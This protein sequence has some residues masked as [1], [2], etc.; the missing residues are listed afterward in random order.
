MRTQDTKYASFSVTHAYKVS[1]RYTS[2]QSDMKVALPCC[3]LCVGEHK[4]V[5]G[6]PGAQRVTAAKEQLLLMAYSEELRAE[7]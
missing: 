1:A 6:G 7:S 4:P 2:A 3:S 5:R